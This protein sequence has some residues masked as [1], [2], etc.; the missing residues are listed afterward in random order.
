MSSQSPD[1]LAAFVL[2]AVGLAFALIGGAIF[3]NHLDRSS[4][5]K[6]ASGEPG[7]EPESQP[8]DDEA[9]PVGGLTAPIDPTDEG[10]RLDDP[11]VRASPTVEARPRKIVTLAKD[12][13][14]GRF[15]LRIEGD[16]YWTAEE[17]RASRHFLL[18]EELAREYARWLTAGAS[19]S[20]LDQRPPLPT[21]AAQAAQGSMIDQIN[22]ILELKLRE[23]PEEKRAIRLAESPDGTVRVFVGV[24]SYAL[25]DVPSP[26]VR[27][28]I[29]A[30]VSEWE[31]R[32]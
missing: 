9:P 14:D 13:L 25:D 1:L 11:R 27:Q 6:T 32:Q 30:A 8:V 18:A 24:E 26:E 22:H 20:P 28:I 31:G 10:S 21:H 19:S 29:R 17:L 3:L 2:I 4:G 23:M 16:E 12:P 15:H 5:R 7:P